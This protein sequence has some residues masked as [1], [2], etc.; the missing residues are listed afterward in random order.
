VRKSTASSRSDGG[1]REFACGAEFIRTPFN[2]LQELSPLPN[3]P[4]NTAVL[5]AD[6]TRR[7]HAT[8]ALP[9]RSKVRRRNDRVMGVAFEM[10]RTAMVRD[11]DGHHADAAIANRIIELAK[12]GERNPD[13]LCEETLKILK[14]DRPLW[15]V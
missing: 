13:R 15:R 4:H 7:I 1:G 8:H 3:W 14:T 9:W 6:L 11:R 5:L 10:A 2:F 12:G